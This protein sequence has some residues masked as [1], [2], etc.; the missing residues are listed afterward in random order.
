MKH[1]PILFW[2]AFLL[3]SG[4][5]AAQDVFTP[6]YVVIGGFEN[7]DNAKR[8]CLYA[9]E[10]NLPAVYAFNEERKL[11]Y[12][13]VRATQ[14]KEVADDIL[15]R[16]RSTTVFKDAWVFSGQLSGSALARYCLPDPRVS[17]AP[18]EMPLL[19]RSGCPATAL[20]GARATLGAG[21]RAGP[22]RSGS[23]WTV[24]PSGVERD[25][26]SSGAEGA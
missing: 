19:C 17:A 13:Y 15:G 12:V 24:T 22:R 7:E 3:V 9:E 11:F 1:A 18:R 8:Y 4:S 2:I 6:Y 23:T 21:S 20:K 25:R 10:Q 14:T 16:L 5:A 26:R